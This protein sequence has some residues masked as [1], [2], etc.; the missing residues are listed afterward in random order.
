MGR[1]PSA[2]S[3]L[4]KTKQKSAF[5]N[6]DDMLTIIFEE[7]E[8]ESKKKILEKIQHLLN[9]NSIYK[10]FKKVVSPEQLYFKEHR[11]QVKTNFPNFKTADVTKELKKLWVALPETL[12]KPYNDK[13]EEMLFN[14]YKSMEENNV[15]IVEIIQGT[16]HIINPYTGK[17]IK[18][19]GISGKKS[20][21]LFSKYKGTNVGVTK[22]YMNNDNPKEID[23]NTVLDD[24][25]SDVE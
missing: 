23:L 14:F 8:Q 22:D 18:S 24:I 3:A 4:E 25:E 6:V 12:K 5:E 9:T 19:S 1:K 2:T 10:K 17:K 11:A 20:L 16:E 13:S 21:D 7:M 15:V